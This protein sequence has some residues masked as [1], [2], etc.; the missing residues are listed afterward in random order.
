MQSIRVSSQLLVSVL[1][2]AVPTNTKDF[3]SFLIYSCNMGMSGLPDLYT[4]GPRASVV[5]KDHKCR[6]TTTVERCNPTAALLILD[7]SWKLIVAHSSLEYRN[8]W[9]MPLTTLSHGNATINTL[10][11]L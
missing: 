11:A 10:S 4:T 7:R 6:I 1:F 2:A 5:Q 9:P 8:V 3:K